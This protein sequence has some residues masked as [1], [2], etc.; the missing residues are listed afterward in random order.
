MPPR[1]VL[2]GAFDRHNFG[3][4]LFPHVVSHL[5]PPHRPWEFAGLVARDLRTHG[6]HRLVPL[7]SIEADE[8]TVLVHC[9]GE[10][11]TCSAYEAAVMLQDDA[12][13]N[14]AI[15]RYDAE[16]V[17]AAR[18]AASVLHTDRA[19][20]YVVRPAAGRVI[21]NAIGGVAW[22]LLTPAQ[23]AEVLDVLGRAQWV[24]VRD[25]LTHSHLR[26]HG[27]TAELCP[28]PAVMVKTCFDDVIQQHSRQG[29]VAE[30]VRAFPH[31]Y[32]A[33]QF[34]AEFGDDVTLDQLAH[35]LARVCKETG[36][37]IVLFRAGAAPWHDRL[38]VYERLIRRLPEHLT[39]TFAS[40]HVWDICALITSSRAFCG[41]SL[42]GSIVAAAYG[43]PHVSLIA[44]QQ[45]NWPSKVEAYWDTWGNE[46]LTLCASM[47]DIERALIEAMTQPLDQW[48]ILAIRSTIVYRASQIQWASILP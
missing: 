6:G 34:S 22:P 30:M 25:H 7:A 47:Y 37:G 8:N 19:M 43:L 18:W 14:E 13:A 48:H 40:L 23:R 41:S 3:D 1:L 15:A 26:A 16:P 45:G 39:R 24:S 17:A 38:D 31:G 36:M 4:L 10:L 46:A 27:I 12:D 2:F 28:D 11:L 44:T 5:L 9:G 32:L 42:H 33:C 35:G 29:E 20:P 21:F